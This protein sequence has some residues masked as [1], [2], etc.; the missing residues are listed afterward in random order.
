M[1]NRIKISVNLI[2][3]IICETYNF[4]IDLDLGVIDDESAFILILYY[5]F[6]NLSHFFIYIKFD[7]L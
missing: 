6:I 7:V 1:I 4:L 3:T 5:S 2:K